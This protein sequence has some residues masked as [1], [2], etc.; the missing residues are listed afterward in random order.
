MNK[1]QSEDHKYTNT[2]VNKIMQRIKEMRI[3]F[4]KDWTS[5]MKA[6]IKL[7]MKNS[8]IQTKI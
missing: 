1:H 3:E 4:N 6:N 5:E 8:E 2:E 7:E